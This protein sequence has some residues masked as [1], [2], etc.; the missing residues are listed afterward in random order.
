MHGIGNFLAVEFVHEFIIKGKH[1]LKSIS[2]MVGRTENIL[3]FVT[4]FCNWPKQGVLWH[5]FFVKVE[6]KN[7]ERKI[8]FVVFWNEYRFDK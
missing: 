4:V 1:C 7:L 2:A 8:N 3:L 5:H 6:R